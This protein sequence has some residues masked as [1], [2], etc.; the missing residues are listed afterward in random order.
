MAPGAALAIGV[1]DTSP[2]WLL[3]DVVGSALGPAQ[4][5]GPLPYPFT[6]AAE[7]CVLGSI[8]HRMRRFSLPLMTTVSL[9]AKGVGN[10]VIR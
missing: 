3:S 7:D 10:T 9:R 1:Q 5:R 2:V 8:L 4:G 6:E